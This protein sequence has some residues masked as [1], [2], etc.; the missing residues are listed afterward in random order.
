LTQGRAG[1][2]GFRGVK[3]DAL[4][5]RVAAE[6]PAGS[7]REQR[8]AGPAFALAEPGAQDSGGAGQQRGRRSLRRL[9]IVWTLAPMPRVMSAMVSPAG[10]EIVSP[11]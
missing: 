5:D 8:V 10:S 9:P 3:A 1:Q 11:A 4:L 6:H 7:G 2:G